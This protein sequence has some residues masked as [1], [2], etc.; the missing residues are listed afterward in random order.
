M[1]D[2][3]SPRDTFRRRNPIQKHLREEGDGVYRL[4]VIKPKDNYKRIHLKPRDIKEYNED[5]DED[6]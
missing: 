3:N 1:S 2:R 5:R 6:L 4:R